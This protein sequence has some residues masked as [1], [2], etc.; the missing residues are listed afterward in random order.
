MTQEII[1]DKQT[2]QSCLSK[3]TYLIQYG[4]VKKSGRDGPLFV[5]KSGKTFGYY[6]EKQ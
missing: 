5:K 3:K 6:T 4:F 2:V 1:L